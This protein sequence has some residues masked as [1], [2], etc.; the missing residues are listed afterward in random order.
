MA[1]GRSHSAVLATKGPS[2]FLA[3]GWPGMLAAGGRFFHGEK[4][5]ILTIPHFFFFSWGNLVTSIFSHTF[6]CSDVFLYCF[7]ILFHIFPNF[8]HTFLYFSDAFPGG[9]SDN[10]GDFPR[11]TPPWSPSKTP[12][13]PEKVWMLDG[14]QWGFWSF[15]PTA[16]VNGVSPK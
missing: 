11:L 10:F 2:L 16:K 4:H 5:G 3:R 13:A 12:T 7:S 15:S 6:P 9:I 14:F 1:A 8:F